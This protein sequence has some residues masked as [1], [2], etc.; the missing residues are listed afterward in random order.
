VATALSTTF[1]ED[2]LETGA[3]RLESL[4]EGAAR[5]AA[6]AGGAAQIAEQAAEAATTVRRRGR[7]F[8]RI[9]MVVVVKVI[10]SRRRRAGDDSIETTPTID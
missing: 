1:V 7:N 10:K 6:L 4:A 5:V 3:A 2:H 8:F 9:G